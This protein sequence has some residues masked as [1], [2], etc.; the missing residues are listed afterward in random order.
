MSRFLFSIFL[1]LFFISDAYAIDINAADASTLEQFN[2]VGPATAQKIVAYRA[3]NGPFSSCDQL[4]NVKGIGQKTLDKI[5]P[6][7]SAGEVEEGTTT[8]APPQKTNKAVV[9]PENA[10]DVNTA[11]ASTLKRFNGVGPATAK[12]IIDYRTEN[13]PF[14]SC[15]DLTKVKGIGKKT[16]EKIKPTCTASAPSSEK[17]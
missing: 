13:G 16:L 6:T 10:I 1:S 8:K 14:S 17:K 11:D 5:K 4:T 9:A 2:G 12:K 15:D 7:C 3:A